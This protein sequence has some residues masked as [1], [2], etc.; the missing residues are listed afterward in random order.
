LPGAGQLLEGTR[1]ERDE[2]L[3]QRGVQLS[4]REER[5]VAQAREDPA[6]DDQNTGFHLRLVTRLTHARR[7][8]RET[9][10]LG[11]VLVARVE[12]GLVAMRALHGALEVVRH[13]GRGNA[14][15]ELQRLH[16]C[17]EPVRQ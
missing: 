12:L 13:D 16:V 5:A 10:V 8:N 14:A 7:Q 17:R 1:V 2:Q 15:E 4:E 9:I 6:L 11:E 3:S